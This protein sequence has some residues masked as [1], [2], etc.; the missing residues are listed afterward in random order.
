[1]N[2]IGT[3]IKRS[4]GGIIGVLTFALPDGS[5]LTIDLTGAPL[6]EGIYQLRTEATD[7]LLRLAERVLGGSVARVIG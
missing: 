5:V 3:L 2:G 6:G 1:M 7:E 4:D